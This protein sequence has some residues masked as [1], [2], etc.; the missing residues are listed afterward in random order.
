MNTSTSIGSRPVFVV[1]YPG[2]VGGANTECWHTVRLWRRFGLEVSLIPTWTAHEAWRR[3]LD[4]LGC[5][6]ILA[7]P[8]S[9]GDVPGLRGAIV[10]SFCNSHFLRNAE[11]FRQLGCKTVW[12]GCMTWLLPE[13]RRLYRR[14]GP[15][16]RYVFQSRFQQAELLPQLE[17]LGVSA[18]QGYQIHG[19]FCWDEFPFVPQ[20]HV[21]DSP[22][23]IGR[24]SRA[25]PD[26]FSA[27]TWAI[28]GR[29]RGPVHARLMAWD[30]QIEK[31]LGPAPAWAECLPAAAEPAGEFLRTLHCLLPINGGAR[32]NWPQ[33]GLEAMA[34]GVPV[35]TENRWGWTEMIRHGETGYLADSDEDLVAYA[36]RLAGDEAHRLA[37]ARQARAALEE[38]LADPPTLWR[39]WKDLF[40]GL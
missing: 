37:I 23:V 35:V 8:E 25:S 34:S 1:G 15:F 26:K 31:R 33:A 32:E 9:L 5:R 18:E 22:F 10:V 20:P 14:I 36:E 30:R 40:E 11:R 24:I 21:A 17:A 6:T 16:D 13:E 3:R 19:A 4:P 38:E 2:D 39:Q 27:R 12:L 29:I 28:Y 7:R